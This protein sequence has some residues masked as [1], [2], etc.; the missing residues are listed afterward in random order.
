[1]EKIG[2]I[3][4]LVLAVFFIVGCSTSTMVTIDSSP[5]GA[6]V[7]LNGQVIGT[8]PIK[9]Y[10]ISNGIGKQYPIILRKEGYPLMEAKLKTEVKPINIVGAI[11]LMYI[12]IIWLEGPQEGQ[13]FVFPEIK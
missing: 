1:M 10:E 2:K 3:A 4:L 12:P 6:E 7:I 5:P 9:D 11:F 8:T 13:Y